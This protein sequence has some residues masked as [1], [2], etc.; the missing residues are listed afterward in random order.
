MHRHRKYS[1]EQAYDTIQGA[2]T[3]HF[4]GNVPASDLLRY[5]DYEKDM[6]EGTARTYIFLMLEQGRLDLGENMKLVWQ[7]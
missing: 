6:D 4:D 7:R 3:S 5:L 1:F 2:I